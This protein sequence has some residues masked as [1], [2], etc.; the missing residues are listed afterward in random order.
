MGDIFLCLFHQVR[1]KWLGRC[2][3][4]LFRSDIF[5]AIKTRAAA[6]KYDSFCR[7]RRHHFKQGAEC[8]SRLC[9]VWLHRSIVTTTNVIRFNRLAFSPQH[10]V[11]AVLHSVEGSQ[12]IT[13]PQQNHVADAER[14]SKNVVVKE[15]RRI[16]ITE[17]MHLRK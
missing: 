4:C 8:G 9:I 13:L 15:K 12:V 11:L 16:H 17:K 3:C 5:L 2:W 10:S 6:S 7:C 1:M 14:N